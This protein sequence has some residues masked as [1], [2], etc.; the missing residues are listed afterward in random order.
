MGG[1]TSR[2]EV[3]GAT[4]AVAVLQALLGN[5]GH[6]CG[7]IVAAGHPGVHRHRPPHLTAPPVRRPF[8]APPH[9]MS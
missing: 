8:N 5:L 6:P 3:P 4:E 9:A 2:G 7:G 1:P